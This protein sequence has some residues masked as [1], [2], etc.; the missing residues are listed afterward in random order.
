MKHKII[1]MLIFIISLAMLSCVGTVEQAAKDKTLT[2]KYEDSDVVFEG[3]QSLIPI[4]HDKIEVYFYPATGG[5]EKYSYKIYYGG[6]PTPQVTSS[7][8]LNTDYRGILRYTISDLDASKDYIIRVDVE[9]QITGKYTKTSTTLNTKTFSNKVADFYGVTAVSNLSGIDGIDSI[10]VRWTHAECIDSLK[11]DQSSDPSRYEII[12]LDRTNAGRTPADFNN[13]DLTVAEGRIVKQIAFENDV[14][15][16]VIRGLSGETEYYVVVRAV[17]KGTVEDINNI[18]LRGEMNNAYLVIKTLS[19]DLSMINFDTSS[20]VLS[21]L[22]GEDAINSIKAEWVKAIGVFDHY[23]LYYA[24]KTA[25]LNI[26]TIPDQCLQALEVGDNQNTTILC[27]KVHYS[28]FNTITTGLL[29]QTDYDYILVLCQTVDCGASERIVGDPQEATTKS[30]N[31]V[32]GGVLSLSQASDISELDSIR[33]NFIPVNLDE[34]YIDGYM[35]EYKDNPAPTEDSLYEVLQQTDSGYL[36]GN[37]YVETFNYL[38]ASSVLIR[39]I[40]YYTGKTYCFKIYPYVY[41]SNGVKVT[42]ENENWQCINGPTYS[43]P[44]QLD[45]KGLRKTLSQD[46]QVTLRWQLPADGLFEE[47]ELYYANVSNGKSLFGSIPVDLDNGSVSDAGRIIINSNIVEY[48]L[49]GFETGDVYEFGILTNFNSTQGRL[50]SEENTNIVRC[51][52]ND[53]SNIECVGGY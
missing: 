39:G 15:D 50:R 46:L 28:E 7:D 27:K 49:S 25:N 35:I 48:T 44:T 12:L 16:V 33:I 11:C 34:T 47:Y 37:L 20:L 53:G 13:Y 4:S 17:H 30:D 38:N 10:K 52:F 41:D 23:R 8:V 9:D 21:N 1:H 3:V 5:T 22:S 29:T 24:P 31:P 36:D 18:Q 43:A 42:F 19:D 32:F 2:I 51:T 26:G 6:N 40:E 14:N 45:F